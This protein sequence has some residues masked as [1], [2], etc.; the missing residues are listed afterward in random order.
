MALTERLSILIDA[1]T[2]G[3]VKEFDKVA[4]STKDLEAGTTRTS[5]ALQS[6]GLSGKVSGQALAAG[7]TAGV[8]TAGAA[9]AAFAIKSVGHFNETAQSVRAFQRVTG[10]SAEDASHFVAAFDD[11]GVSAEQASSSMFKLSKNISTGGKALTDLGIGIEHTAN[12]STD[13]QG[14]FL[15]IADA[16]SKTSDPAKRAEIAFAAFGKSGAA[17]LPILEKGKK[18]IEELF[19]NSDLNFSQAQ[20]DSAEDYRLAMDHL[21]DSIGKVQN[22]IGGALVPS[23]AQAAEGT[24]VLVDKTLS[25]SEHTGVL[26]KAFGFLASGTPIGQVEGL[27]Q[28]LGSLADNSDDSA[29]SVDQLAAA[30]GFLGTS[31]DSLAGKTADQVSALVEEKKALDDVY[32]ATL[33]Q[34]DANFGYQ[35]ALNAT[36]DAA[37]K[38]TEA[39]TALNEARKGGDHAAITAAEENL[40][41]ALLSQQEQALQ[42]ATAAGRLAE[43]QAKAA[44]A[45]D[46]VTPKI[47]A[48][49]LELERQKQQIAGAGGNTTVIQQMIDKLNAIKSQYKTTVDVD[50]ASANAKLDAFLRK[51]DAGTISPRT[52][53]VPGTRLNT[54][55]ID[56]TGRRAAGGPVIAGQPYI[57]GEHRPELFVPSQNGTIVPRVGGGATYN[58][59]M[60]PGSDGEDVVAA[61]KN[62]ERRNGTAWRN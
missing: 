40:S 20:L 5:K 49:I 51:L 8:A 19:K 11:M 29:A 26:G 56:K 34:F 16:V 36:E 46:L 48:Q 13:L 12:G 23:L 55:S 50:T 27:V 6:M 39:Q 21:G 42:A 33:A 9:I 62:Y 59:Y 43:E 54:S 44:G 25:A 30:S 61:I 22:R 38:V 1:K 52:F 28:G 35:D 31:M 60:P 15:N 53:E 37:A 58:I 24:A 18:G 10:Q 47:G 41:R 57:V 4:K 32:S 17:L 45:T 3:A 2:G 7:V 14:T